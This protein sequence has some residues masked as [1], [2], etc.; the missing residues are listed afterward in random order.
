MESI[1]KHTLTLAI[2][3]ATLVTGAASPKLGRC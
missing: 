2:A 3:A 1:L